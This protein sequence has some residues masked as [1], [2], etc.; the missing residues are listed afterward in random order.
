MVE[1]VLDDE[2]YPLKEDLAGAYRIDDRGVW[3]GSQVS[4]MDL[5][6]RPSSELSR[7]AVLSAVGMPCKFPVAE[8]MRLDLQDN[9][10]Q[11][12]SDELL[13]KTTRFVDDALD[14]G[15]LV[16]IHCAA[17]ISRST[18]LACAWIVRRFG[19]NAKEALVR[20]RRAGNLRANPNPRFWSCLQ[21][22]ANL[23]AS[24]EAS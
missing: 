2:E 9:A 23:S 16:L 22:F 20:V 21:R 1:D 11:E 5:L 10:E 12:L 18:A 13:E 6:S 24:V 4:A 19:C 8:H 17:G 3:Q 14:R 7:W 15:L